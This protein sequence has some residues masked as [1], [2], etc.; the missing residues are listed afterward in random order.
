[1]RTACEWSIFLWVSIEGTGLND[2]FL[3]GKTV[4][5][6]FLRLTITGEMLRDVKRGAEI[7]GRGT[8]RKG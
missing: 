6:S 5:A 1:M 3:S 7:E 4:I 2:I 8:A